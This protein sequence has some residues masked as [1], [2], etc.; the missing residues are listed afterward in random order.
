[1]QNCLFRQL[2]GAVRCDHVLKREARIADLVLLQGFRAAARAAETGHDR[3]QMQHGLLADGGQTVPRVGLGDLALGPR[4]N[5]K[6]HGGQLR[7]AVFVAE[8]RERDGGKVLVVAVQD[9]V[10]RADAVA[11][12]LGLHVGL[13][14]AEHGGVETVEPGGVAAV[15][16]VLVRAVTEVGNAAVRAV[17]N[18]G[19]SVAVDGDGRNGAENGDLLLKI[20]IL[21]DPVYQRDGDDL[22]RIINIDVYTA[23]LGGKVEIDTM[24]G[25]VNVP[26]KPQTQNNSML[27]LKGLGMPHYGKE[28]S[29]A[30]LLKVQLILPDHFSEKQLE[31][32][33]QAKEA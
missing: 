17:E 22:T 3:I 7:F 28:G 29:G 4:G 24:K 23:I 30:L 32:I 6:L 12:A 16:V 11:V 10:L 13:D 19:E 18:P 14:H 9:H 1:M 27:R 20:H 31:L 26:I 8:Q 15:A 25:T 5:G 21:Q 33:K 2:F